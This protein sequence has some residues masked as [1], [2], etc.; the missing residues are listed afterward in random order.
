[1]HTYIRTYIHTYMC[2]YIYIYI[3]THLYAHIYIYIYIYIYIVSD[4]LRF[5]ALRTPRPKVTSVLARPTL[6]G[7]RGYRV[8]ASPLGPWRQALRVSQHPKGGLSEGWFVTEY[9]M[10][11]LHVVMRMGGS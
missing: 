3:Y 9:A 11:L 6:R 1:M 2:I 4:L 10:F 5:T 8:R 7:H